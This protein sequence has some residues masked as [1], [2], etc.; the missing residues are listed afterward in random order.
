MSTPDSK[1]SQTLAALGISTAEG[2]QSL[3]AEI[4]SRFDAEASRAADEASFKAF[5][6]A[7]LGRK[8]GVI[9]LVTDNWLKPASSDL[10]RSV[11]AALNE[12]RAHVDA[13][14]EV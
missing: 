6:D 7:W 11:G 10:K 8:S 5:R 13:Q 1:L 2:L 4:R 14:I 9:T 12:L 3:F